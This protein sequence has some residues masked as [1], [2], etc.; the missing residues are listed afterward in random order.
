MYGATNADYIT[1]LGFIVINKECVEQVKTEALN[2]QEGGAK[3]NK[4]DGDGEEELD[5]QGLVAL[6]V[7][8]AMVLITIIFVI[9]V[10]CYK[11]CSKS[12]T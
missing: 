1:E 10:L 11:S 5:V 3:T 4:S 6:G 2:V 12:T 7:I 8:G 9:V